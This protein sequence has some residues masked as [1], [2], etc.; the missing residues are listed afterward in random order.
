MIRQELKIRLTKLEQRYAKAVQ[1]KRYE[2]IGPAY[3]ACFHAIQAAAVVLHGEPKID[4]PLMVAI[5][6]MENKL[7]NEFKAAAQKCWI[8][9]FGQETLH[10]NL[11]GSYYYP[12]LMFNALPGPDNLKFEQIF[13][14]APVWFLKFTGVEW[15]AKILGFKLRELVGA[16]ELGSDAWSERKFN[17]PRLPEGTIDA[18]GPFPVPDEPWKKI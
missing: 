17:W 12:E 1:A 5:G 3:W 10:R 4:E 13:S 6:R 14:N 2:K 15:D 7:D 9:D 16:P 11:Q 8:R 18:G